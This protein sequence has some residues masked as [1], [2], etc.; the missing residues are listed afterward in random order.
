MIRKLIYLAAPYTSNPEEN[1]KKALDAA[2]IVFARGYIPYVPHLSHHW[3]TQSPKSYEQWMEMGSAV[4]ER[5]D[6]VLRLPGE[7][8][9]ADE[10]VKQAQSIGKPVYYGLEELPIIPVMEGCGNMG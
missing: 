6:A 8:P 4:L 3:H 5:C 9:G 1:V 2:D 7:S 10:E